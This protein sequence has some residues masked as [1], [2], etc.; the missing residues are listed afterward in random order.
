MVK[1]IERKKERVREIKKKEEKNSKIV[2]ILI[3]IIIIF[4]LDSTVLQ[5]LTI[6]QGWTS[7]ETG[8]FGMDVL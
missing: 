2:P 6:D 8:E 7:T 4:N 5:Q 1:K 3:I